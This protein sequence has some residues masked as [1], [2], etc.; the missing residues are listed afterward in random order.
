MLYQLTSTSL[1]V[2]RCVSLDS[3]LYLF[4]MCTSH[5]LSTSVRLGSRRYEHPAFEDRWLAYS[6]ILCLLILPSV[7]L[8]EVLSLRLFTPDGPYVCPV[9][10]CPWKP[11]LQCRTIRLRDRPP[12]QL[13]RVHPG[14]GSSTL[15]HRRCQVGG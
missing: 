10:C 8:D 15:T 4:Y 2:S 11:D 12:T 9:M 13:E 5:R 3:M 7:E 1:T 6:A 14:P